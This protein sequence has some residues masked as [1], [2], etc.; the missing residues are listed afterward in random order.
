MEGHRR[1]TKKREGGG[2]LR[3]YKSWKKTAGGVRYHEGRVCNK[4]GVTNNQQ[5]GSRERVLEK[6]KGRLKK[7]SKGN[8]TSTVKEIGPQAF[9]M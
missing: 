7:R 1:V 8:G 2:K 3:V 4:M 6:S 9:P 5:V